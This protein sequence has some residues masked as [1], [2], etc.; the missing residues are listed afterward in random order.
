ML[1]LLQYSYEDG[2]YSLVGFNEVLLNGCV[3]KESS[4]L[5]MEAFKVSIS[6]LFLNAEPQPV[7]AG[8][9]FINVPHNLLY[10]FVYDFFH[11][12]K[13]DSLQKLMMSNI[14]KVSPVSVDELSFNYV[15][16]DKG[17]TFSYAAYAV[18][19]K[20]QD[21]L[22][23]ALKEVGVKSIEFIPEPVAEIS[24]F[25]EAVL[26]DFALFSY[27]RGQIFISVFH[28]GLLYDSYSLGTFVEDLSADCSGCLREFDRT[29]KEMESQ[30][31]T[32][33]NN[34]YFI[35][36][37]DNQF[38]FIEKQFESR[39]ESIAFIRSEN[40]VLNDILPYTNDKLILFGLFNYVTKG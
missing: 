34:V 29:T 37:T 18:L 27:F 38:Q 16:T 39:S 8:R 13:E 2:R 36:F 10:S 1:Q 31:G 9:L 14:E 20:W 4:I 30:F 23:T 40:S 21:R 22:L 35:G 24:L 33:L 15:M 6:E 11:H 32:K 7:K 25:G 28:N 3:S 12:F 26:N 17:H 5:D 19:K